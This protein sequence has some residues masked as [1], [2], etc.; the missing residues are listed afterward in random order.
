MMK[1]LVLALLCPLFAQ[2]YATESV[3]SGFPDEAK[4]AIERIDC[5]FTIYRDEG[6]ASGTWDDLVAL[7]EQ[8]AGSFHASDE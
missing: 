3:Y 1:K 8:A 7:L 4:Q 2:V 5:T 6:A